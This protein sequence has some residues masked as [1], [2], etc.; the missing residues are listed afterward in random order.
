MRIVRA[1]YEILGEMDGQEMLRHI[2]CCGR[3]CYKS[4]EKIGAESSAGFVRNIIRRDHTSVIE[5]VSFTVR[6]IV[7]RGISHEIVRHRIASYSQES[8]RYCNYA[9]GKFGGEVTVIAPCFW[10]EGDPPFQ[11]WKAACEA[12]EENYFRLLDQ[13][14]T[15]QEARSVLPGSL[16]TELMMTANLREWRHFLRLR[17][18]KAAHPQV[19]EVAIPLLSELQKK[20]PIIFDDIEVD[21]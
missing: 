14:A 13:G 10:S 17:T 11:T 18:A 20:I 8:T 6:F 2:E 19:R 3:V 7:D 9:G 1:G 15:P 4:E 16:K 5:H 21:G 12:A